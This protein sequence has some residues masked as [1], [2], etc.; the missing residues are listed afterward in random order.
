MWMKAELLSSVP[1]TLPAYSDAEETM[2]DTFRFRGNPETLRNGNFCDLRSKEELLVMIGFCE[3][4][5]EASELK[6]ADEKL[7][8]FTHSVEDAC[9]HHLRGFPELRSHE[10]TLS[11]ET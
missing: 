4:S 11:Q 7:K 9:R 3:P 10:I 5:F 6:Q 1:T 2:K 8:L